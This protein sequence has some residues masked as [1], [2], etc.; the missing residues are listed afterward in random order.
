MAGL[1]SEYMDFIMLQ[2][3][4]RNS[5]ATNRDDI[6]AMKSVLMKAM[7]KLNLHQKD[8]IYMHFFENKSVSEIAAIKGSTKSNI[9]QIKR[10][11]IE[12]IKR[13]IRGLN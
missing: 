8:V 5:G 9:S 1:T 2:N 4:H 13:N 11:G 12:N 10:R 6:K 7:K 3:E